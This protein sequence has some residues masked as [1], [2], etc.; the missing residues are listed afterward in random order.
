MVVEYRTEHIPQPYPARLAISVAF[1][2]MLHMYRDLIPRLYS[3]YH[4]F[5]PGAGP[6]CRH[7][8]TSL[9]RH[10][11][12]SLVSSIS[13]TIADCPAHADVRY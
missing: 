12:V 1:G 3:R 13:L 10:D 2:V 5:D 7:I 8:F 9:V 4:I 11:K 6:Q